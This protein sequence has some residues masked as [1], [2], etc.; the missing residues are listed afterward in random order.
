MNCEMKKNKLILTQAR[1]T[2]RKNISLKN[3]K[4]MQI[5]GKQ[6]AKKTSH[7]QSNIHNSDSSLDE[8]NYKEII[9]MKKDG[10][11]YRPNQ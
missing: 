1:S 9:Y 4:I 10:V 2:W 11:F 7:S 8:N 6:W 3:L 5:G